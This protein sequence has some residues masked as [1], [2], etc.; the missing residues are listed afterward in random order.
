MTER[1]YNMDYLRIFACFMVIFLHAST[2]N[3]HNTSVDSIEWVIFT[4]YDS[5]VR[6]AVPLFFMLSGALFLSKKHCPSPLQLF[7]KNILKL[8]LLYL[9]W[10]FFYAID[11]IGL[12]Q[13]LS[14]DGITVLMENMVDAKYH[15]WYIPRLIG[16]YFLIPVLWTICQYENGKYLKYALGMFFI[17]CI[18]R[19]T[20]DYTP[21]ENFSFY[22]ICDRF[23]YDLSGYSGYFLLGYYLFNNKEK[24]ITI[25]SLALGTIF[26]L[27]VSL[28]S[29]ITILYSQYIGA[30]TTIM[31]TNLS[32][33]PFIESVILFL[34]FMRIQYRP[35]KIFQQ[36]IIRISKYTLQVYFIHVFVLDRLNLYLNLTSLS[37]HPLLSVPLLAIVVLLICLVFSILLDCVL[38]NFP[39]IKRFVM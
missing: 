12:K 37:L 35:S 7:K 25:S 4:F 32:I 26:L 39:C 34:L 19:N 27:V 21:I 31:M 30:A 28:S 23:I 1:N 6:S 13:L 36:Y 24:Y 9:L 2:Q 11:T 3:W 10:D 29:I 14:N 17:F 20:L 15:L 38:N 18:C 8:F 5:L 22:R 33:S 16:V